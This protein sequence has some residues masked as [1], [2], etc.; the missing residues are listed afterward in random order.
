MGFNVKTILSKTLPA[1]LLISVAT[2]FLPLKFEGS[3]QLEIILADVG[4]GDAILVKTPENQS[5]LIDGGPNNMVLQKLGDYLPALIKRI[6]IVLLTHPHA[7]HV[8]GLIEVLKRY[9]IGAL[10]LSGA[11]L[12]TDVYSEFLEIVKEKNIPIIVAEAGEAIHFGPAAAGLEFDILSPG[13][14]GDLIFNKKSEGFGIGGNDV[15]DTSIVGKLMFKNFSI[16]LTG[17]A[18][19]KIENQLYPQIHNILFYI[20]KNNP[21]GAPPKNPEKDSQFKNW[22]DA[23]L[24]WAEENIANFIANYN[25]PLPLGLQN[26]SETAPLVSLINLISPKNGGFV[27]MGE[28]ISVQA[29]IQS[30]LDIG[31]IQLIFNNELMD[32][33][34]ENFGKTAIYQ[35]N[36]IP[37]KV[38]LQNLLKIK[39]FDSLNNETVKE[40]IIFSR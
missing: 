31:K 17:D 29:Q 7:D 14:S 21:A 30:Q 22:E 9:E 5:M 39:I 13:R 20:D 19:Y 27:K 11:D 32:E 35:F 28:I 24:K 33:R 15:N 3:T 26:I 23:V 36:L 37:K 1:I 34:N 2:W 16:L 25:H 40:I 8:A 4:Q 38:E 10:V 12:K 6:D 18:T